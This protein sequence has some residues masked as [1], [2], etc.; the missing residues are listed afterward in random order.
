MKEE[1]EYE[2]RTMVLGM[3]AGVAFLEQIA[4][5]DD[6]GL[7]EIRFEECCLGQAEANDA[8]LRLQW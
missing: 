8:K 4:S 5:I 6:I 7:P 2:T 1:C 3:G